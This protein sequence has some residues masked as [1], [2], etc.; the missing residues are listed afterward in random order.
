MK[1]D[2]DTSKLPES[3]EKPTDTPT[4]KPTEAY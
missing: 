3:T 4:E 1:T 2:T